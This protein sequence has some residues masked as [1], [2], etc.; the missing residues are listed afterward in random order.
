ML[1]VLC[2]GAIPGLAD[3]AAR[4][5]SRNASTSVLRSIGFAREHAIHNSTYA[6]I[7]PSRDGI[8]CDGRWGSHLIVFED[9]AGSGKLESE[10]DVLSVAHLGDDWQIRWKAFGGKSQLTLTARGFTIH[11][12][13]SFH[14]CPGR[15]NLEPR[16]IVVNKA[17]RGR[18]SSGEGNKVSC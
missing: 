3:L 2:F 11:Q 10:E 13:G 4:Q 7:C 8:A 15:S 1:G 5:E 18:I 12:N 16:K 17:G 14:L 6:S 9:E